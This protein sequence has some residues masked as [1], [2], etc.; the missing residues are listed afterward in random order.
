M[1]GSA[2]V[3][4]GAAKRGYIKPLSRLQSFCGTLGGLSRAG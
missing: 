2:G 3:A 1:I 4:P